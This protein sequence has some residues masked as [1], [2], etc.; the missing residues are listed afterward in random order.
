M[1]LVYIPFISTSEDFAEG[2]T[3]GFWALEPEFW[4]LDPALLGM[5]S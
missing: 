3:K 1:E 4:A 5:E 2:W